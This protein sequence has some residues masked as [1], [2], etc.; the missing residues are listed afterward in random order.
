M[1]T[2]ESNPT[3]G[4]RLPT[5]PATLVY[6]FF[7]VIA[8]FWPAEHIPMLAPVIKGLPLTLLTLLSARSWLAGERN[9]FRLF[10]T[11]GLFFS[12]IGDLAI[13]YVFVGGI[14]SFLLAHVAYIVAMGKFERRSRDFIG[15]MPGVILWIAMYAVL[16][17]RVPADLYVAVVV[18]MT[19]ISLMLG[20]AMGRLL[21]DPE[22]RT[23]QLFFVGAVLFVISDSLLALNRWVVDLPMDRLLI[24]GTYLLAQWFI[25][26]GV[27]PGKE[28]PAAM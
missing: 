18:Y 5:E 7:S 15:M 3:P 11:V 24:L 12:L 20:R 21:C 6:A 22:D 14:A 28:R 27:S 26:H 23:R 4:H 2:L 10:V 9:V 17:D 16:A 8:I 25:L 13:M 19:I 1:Q